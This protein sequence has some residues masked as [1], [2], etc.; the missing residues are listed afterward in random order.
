MKETRAQ[1]FWWRTLQC[2]LGS[3]GLA[4]LTFFAFR[5][6]ALPGEAGLVYSFFI[7]LF[8]SWAGFIPSIF[9]SVAAMFC[10]DYFFTPPIF[11]LDITLS[12]RR[13]PVALV[14]FLG[15]AFIVSRLMTGIRERNAALE[16]TNEQVRAE[17]AERGRAEE[18]VRQSEAELRQLIDVIPQ[19]VFVFNSDWTPLFAN[20]GELEYT[21]L[22][23]QE[24]QSKDTVAKIF[25][26]EDFKKL[27]VLRERMGA[28]GT[29]FE[30]EARIRG[31]DGQD[32]VV[33][34]PRQST[35]GCARTRASLVRH[36]D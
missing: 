3:I 21:G 35:V 33:L 29:P 12:E 11:S 5:L 36:A 25:H 8:A 13:D 2:L 30:M 1:R 28:H 18:K 32:P 26:P 7:V 4:L 34:D 16:K 10:F 19:Q 23:L 15:S 22:T 20:R 31:E 27:V 14:T 9:I 17:I 6:K 24:A